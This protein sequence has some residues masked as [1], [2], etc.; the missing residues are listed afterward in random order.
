VAI[1]NPCYDFPYRV[2][3]TGR[4]VEVEQNTTEE[5]ANCVQVALLTPTGTVDL[6]P[7]YGTAPR[8]FSQLPADTGRLVGQAE[9]CEPRASLLAEQDLDRAV[10][11]VLAV[12]V[13]VTGG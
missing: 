8:V 13:E 3:N 4:P 2:D 6:I 5:I 1:E 11:G 7:E 9:R 12:R 10:D